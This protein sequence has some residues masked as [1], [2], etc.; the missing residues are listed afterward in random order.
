MSLFERVKSDLLQA[1]RGG[2]DAA[3]AA[4]SLRVLVG[5]AV[6]MQKSARRQRTGPLDDAETLSL[7]QRSV[8][9]LNE[10]IAQATSLG[11][12][13]SAAVAERALLAA[14]LPVTLTDGE[15]DSVIREVLRRQPDARLG[16]VMRVLQ[17]DHRGQ[18]DGNV[19][20]IR[21]QALLADV[22]IGSGR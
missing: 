6:G 22:G 16:D 4:G 11:R 19:A 13:T 7:I 18:Y 3:A 5:E 8:V 2:P 17:A 12:D 21:A 15:L 20:R 1:R 9:G 10:A 14:Y